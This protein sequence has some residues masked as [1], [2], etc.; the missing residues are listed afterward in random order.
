MVENVQYIAHPRINLAAIRRLHMTGRCPGV[1][2]P[3]DK[4]YVCFIF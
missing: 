4:F 3:G 1:G 2:A